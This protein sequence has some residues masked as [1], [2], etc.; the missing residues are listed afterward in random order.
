MKRIRKR[1]APVVAILRFCLEFKKKVS[2]NLKSEQGGF[3]VLKV[4]LKLNRSSV[5]GDFKKIAARMA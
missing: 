4:F 2:V 1:P 3:C 5:N